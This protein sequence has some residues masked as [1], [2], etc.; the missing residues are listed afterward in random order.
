MDS[1][2]ISVNK[3]SYEKHKLLGLDFLRKIKLTLEEDTESD[4]IL[5]TLEDLL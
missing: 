1:F 4:N 2:N 5:M 3:P